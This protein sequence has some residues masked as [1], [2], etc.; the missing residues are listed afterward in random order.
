[1][2]ALFWLLIVV[3]LELISIGPLFIS[4]H[5]LIGVA[6]ARELIPEYD[7]ADDFTA[8]DY[9]TP[10]SGPTDPEIPIRHCSIEC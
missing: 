10:G 6:G 4:F 8:E 3:P 2:F 9:P 5:A 1:V 7:Y